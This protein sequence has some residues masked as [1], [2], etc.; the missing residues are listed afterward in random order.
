M[1]YNS[2]FSLLLL[3]NANDVKGEHAHKIYNRS[4]NDFSHKTGYR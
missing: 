4:N 2:L 1:T 3:F